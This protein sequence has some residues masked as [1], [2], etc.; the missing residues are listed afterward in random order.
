M[1]G[2]VRPRKARHA[3]L[4]TSLAHDSGSTPEAVQIWGDGFNT[5]LA[6]REL[7]ARG[8]NWSEGRIAKCPRL[9]QKRL[10]S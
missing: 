5:P 3:V 8:R 7:R 4:P 10:S 2:G 9:Q 1:R 6:Q